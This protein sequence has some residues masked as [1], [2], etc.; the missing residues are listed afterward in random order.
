MRNLQ[1]TQLL[2]ELSQPGRRGVTMPGCDVPEESID[3]LL[4][5]EVR[6]EGPPPLPELP[7]PD[8]IRHF[9]NL[10]TLNM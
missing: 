1:A 9:T 8:V 10:S 4:P 6:A 5:V 2:F 7:E 3:S